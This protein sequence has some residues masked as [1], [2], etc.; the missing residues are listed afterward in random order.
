MKPINTLGGQQEEAQ[1]VNE[2]IKS[3]GTYSKR[4][5]LKSKGEM[6]CYILTAKSGYFMLHYFT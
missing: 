5:V 1:Q 4:C 6:A 2:L 3:G